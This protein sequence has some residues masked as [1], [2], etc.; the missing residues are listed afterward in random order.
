MHAGGDDGGAVAE[1]VDRTAPCSNGGGDD[2]TQQQEILDHEP[3]V[4]PRRPTSS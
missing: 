3:L 1:G 2:A 4:Q